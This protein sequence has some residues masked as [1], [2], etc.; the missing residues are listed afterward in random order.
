MHPETKACEVVRLEGVPAQH[1]CNLI[2]RASQQLCCYPG[3]D[4]T[5]LLHNP[6]AHLLHRP[7][8]TSPLLP[9]ADLLLGG[10]QRT[11]LPVHVGE[12]S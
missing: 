6:N 11:V 9:R 2:L 4:C 5:A 7:S 3:T 12:H 10:L 1:S 8:C